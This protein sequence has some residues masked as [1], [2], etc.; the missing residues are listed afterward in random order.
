M[1]DRKDI[2]EF[3]CSAVLS[4][5]RN[6]ISAD[7]PCAPEDVGHAMFGRPV[8]AVGRADDPLWEAMKAPE[9]VGRLFRTPQEWL[10]GARSVLSYFVPFTDYVTAGNRGPGWPGAGWICA[11][12][13]GQ[14]LLTSVCHRLE[15]YL[16]RGGYEALGPSAGKDFLSV[17]KA[18]D[19]PRTAGLS[20]TSNWSERHV[21]YIC[22]LGTFGLTRALITEK[23][24]A[25]RLGSVITTLPLAPDRRNYTGLT[26]YCT[27]C[28]AC[29]ARCPAGAVR[30]GVGK[31]QDAC[32]AWLHRIEQRYP[33]CH[34]CGKCMAGVPCE[35]GIPARRAQTVRG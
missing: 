31:D 4:D 28:G 21:G 23:G 34:G 29:A 24:V 25:G 16:R 2:E 14:Q 13:W 20:Y 35:H 5:P 1:M 6:L 33:G 15:A 32:Q 7:M 18:G 30:P 12:R 8:L 22:G 9:A 11:S 27:D 10:P 3:L 26:A 17:G 19:D